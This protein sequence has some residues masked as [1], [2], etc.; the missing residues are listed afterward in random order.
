MDRKIITRAGRDYEAFVQDEMEI[1]IGPP[2]GL[3]DAL[4]LPEPIATRLHNIL[5]RRGYYSYGTFDT[6]GLLGALQEVLMVDAQR[7]SELYFK[8]HQEAQDDHK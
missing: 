3:V 5:H 6:K 8:F 1:I 2:E 7:L 4:E